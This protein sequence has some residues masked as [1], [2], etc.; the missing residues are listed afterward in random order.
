[1]PSER[2]YL[3]GAGFS[4]S[5]SQDMSEADKM[6]LLN[7]LSAAVR[8]RV[9]KI[10]GHDT[11]LAND[12]EQWLSYLIDNP[13]WLTESDRD[14]NRAAFRDISLAVHDVLTERQRSLVHQMPQPEWLKRLV[15]RWHMDSAWVITFN[16]DQLVEVAWKDQS[17]KLL[18]GT[19]LQWASS[20]LLYPVAVTP[21]WNRIGSARGVEA[22]AF[23]LKL[24]KLHG[25]LGWWYSGLGSPPNDTIYDWPLT[26]GW[27]PG[28]FPCDPPSTNPMTSGLFPMIIPPTAVKS[29]YYSNQT[30]QALW[31]KAAGALREAKE[32]VVMGFSLPTTDMLVSSMLRTTLRPDVKIIPVDRSCGIVERL[33]DTL[34]LDQD[35]PRLITDFAGRGDNAIRDWVDSLGN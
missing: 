2:V 1:V 10:P 35:G 8:N 7:E 9:E 16:Y 18:E 22:P 28:N 26:D 11:L 3:L 29:P 6:P 30:V 15:E 21:I 12:F 14:R 19:L 20:S 27:G 24:L 13:P 4:R 34:A 17:A 25:S 23:G 31:Q 33:R 5:I 32:L